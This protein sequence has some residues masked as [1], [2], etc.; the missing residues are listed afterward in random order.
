MQINYKANPTAQRFHASNKVVRGF[1]GPVGN[2]KSVACIM[3]ILRL[4]HAQEP[5]VDGI[6]KTRWIAI[7]N[8]VPELRTTT[9]NTWKQWV[10]EVIC[11]ITMHPVIIAKMDQPLQDGTRIQM[12]VIFLAIDHPDTT[13]K[14]LGAEVSG[15]W[16]NEAKELAYSVVTRSRERIGRYPARVDGYNVTDAESACT[17]KCVLMDTNPPNDDHWW[18]QLAE[19]G[20]LKRTKQN[21]I[22]NANV[23]VAELF[24]FFRG[25]TPLLK[26]KDG[27]FITNPKAENINNLPGGHQYYLDMIA[28]NTED[29]I[30]VMVLGNYGSIVD[31]RAVY[32]QY[33]DRIHCP[34]EGVKPIRGLSI[35]LGWDFGLDSTVVIGQL[36]STGQM[37]VFDELCADGMTVRQF[38]RDVVKP[39]LATYYKD[40]TIAFS[41]GDP[42]GH[43]T[44]ANSESEAKGAIGI[45]NDDYE[46]EALELGFRTEPAPGNNNIVK[47]L[48]AVVGFLTKMVDA[49]EPGY[50]L[51]SKCN[52]LRKGKN[53]AYKFKK[54]LMRGEERY[55]NK[56]DKNEYSHPADAEQYLAL[57]F[58]HGYN[59]DVG[60]EEEYEHPKLANDKWY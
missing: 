13:R 58:L 39:H 6:R 16:I 23:E 47:R 59:Y 45:L 17:R 27:S 37:R 55:H 14:L 12:E 30:N 29:H 20:H 53:G 41:I 52:M 31:G 1:M 9:L 8:T 57:G 21:E 49:G 24:D 22:D 3:E 33:N 42:S 36:T 43:N 28:G 50:L 25:P 15:I 54:I 46:G 38:A 10:P 7:R 18:Y 19:V 4:A 48:D 35:G 2:G 51:D 11:P 40:F 56:P 44:T 26:Q 32:P 5:N 34:E 60:E